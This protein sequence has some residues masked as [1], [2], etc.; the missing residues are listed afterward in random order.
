MADLISIKERKALIKI[1]KFVHLQE[2]LLKETIVSSKI[3]ISL[4]L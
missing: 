4:K 1:R 3:R 2:I